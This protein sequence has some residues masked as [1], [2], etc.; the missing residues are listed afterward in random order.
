MRESPRFKR[1]NSYKTSLLNAD[2]EEYNHRKK[3][4]FSPK[5]LYF[6]LVFKSKADVDMARKIIKERK[7]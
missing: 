5:F 7:K 2:L 1:L 4:H 3:S 6:G